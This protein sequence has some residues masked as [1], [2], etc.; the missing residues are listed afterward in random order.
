MRTLQPQ[1]APS[2]ADSPRLHKQAFIYLV[3]AGRSAEGGQ[4][5]KADRI[6]RQWEP[7]FLLATEGR[8]RAETR[9]Q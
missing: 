2:A 4:I 7:F 9:L 5:D 6:R 8:M 1:D 3:S